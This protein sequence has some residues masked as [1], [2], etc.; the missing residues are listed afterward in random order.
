MTTH[1]PRRL[2]LLCAL[3]AVLGLAASLAAWLLIRLIAILTNAALFHRW[4]TTLPDFA[5]LPIGPGV[6]LVA[7]GRR[8][9]RDPPGRGGRRSSAGTASPRPWRRC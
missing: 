1:P 6:V 5:D 4:G 9:R 8:R 7:D 2:L 3:S